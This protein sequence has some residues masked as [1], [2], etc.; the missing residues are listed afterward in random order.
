[1]FH[2]QQLRLVLRGSNR[3][4]LIRVLCQVWEACLDL[5][6]Q[7]CFSSTFWW[8]FDLQVSLALISFCV[9]S[10][11]A[12]VEKRV[13]K[14][15]A[16]WTSVPSIPGPPASRIPPQ[17]PLWSLWPSWWE[18][19]RFVCLFLNFIQVDVYSTCSVHPLVLSL[20]IMSVILIFCMHQFQAY[21]T[22]IQIQVITKYWASFH[23]L[24]SGSLLLICFIYSSVCMLI[25]LLNYI[26][27]M[28][29]SYFIL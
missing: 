4:V 3:N 19:H 23:V 24:Y 25:K 2:S 6:P 27:Y 12:Q 1:M 15:A 20:S 29:T 22:V 13:G 11:E 7:A 5:Q 8:H 18:E 26:I 28:T 17:V 16:Q 14:C 21:C 10:G 9:T